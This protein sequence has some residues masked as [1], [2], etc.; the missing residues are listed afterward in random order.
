MKVEIDVDY[1]NY[2][3]YGN[4]DCG[5]S[6]AHKNCEKDAEGKLGFWDSDQEND[7]QVIMQTIVDH[8]MKWHYH[9]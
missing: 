7:V 2:R 6:I 8:H 5:F 4:E 1:S 3:V 9:E